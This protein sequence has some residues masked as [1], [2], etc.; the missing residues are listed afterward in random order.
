[1]TSYQQP[2]PSYQPTTQPDA[3]SPGL[4]DRAGEAADQGKQA[5]GQVAQ[6][7]AEQAKD[8]K[9]EAA[10]QARDLA[11]EAKQKVA[12]QAGEQ[13]RNLV[14]NLR[15]L[16]SELQSM[17]EGS[18]QSGTATELASQ[19]RDRVDSLAGW[20]D[21]R[22]PSDLLDEARNFARRRPGAF[23]LGALAAGV[24]A[25]RLTRG[26]VGAHSDGIVGSNSGASTTQG[27]GTQGY[28]TQGYGSTQGYGQTVAP[29]GGYASD[30]GYGSTSTYGDGG[31]AAYPATDAGYESGYQGSHED[32]GYQ[33]GGTR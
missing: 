16:S 8:V 31:T 5:V 28:G 22:E 19:A 30:A 2:T 33:P 18:Q 15:S 32:P 14:Q 12:D 7:A 10:R 9:N 6:T 1:M 23:L 29:V 17:V 11:G 25:G 3:G 20:L 27:Y 21:G 13:H 24:V 4:S 26:A